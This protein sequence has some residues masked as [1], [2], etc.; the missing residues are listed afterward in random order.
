VHCDLK[1]HNIL[2]DAGGGAKVA[3]FGI[4]HVSGEMLTRSWMTPAGFVAGTLPYMSPEQTDGVRDDPR[5]DVYAVGAVLYRMLTGQTYLDFD[6]RETPL[7]QAVNVQRILDEQPSPPS[8]HTQGI[9]AWLD[10]VV[11]QA[12]AKRPEARYADA[13]TMGAAL[14]QERPAAPPVRSGKMRAPARRWFW[15]VVGA[16]AVLAVVLAIVMAMLLGGGDGRD[17]AVADVTTAPVLP[18]I[19]AFTLTPMPT[20][21]DTHRPGDILERMASPT[22]LTSA[23]ADTSQFGDILERV[24]TPTPLAPTATDRPVPTAT[25]VPPE[26][27]ATLAPTPTPELAQTRNKDGMTM[28]YVP[29][30]EFTMGSSNADIGALLAECSDCTRDSF[31]DEQ[32]QHTVYLDA[33]WI[34]RTEVTNAQFRKCVEAGTCQA[35]T[36]CASG[37]PTYNDPGMGAHPVVCVGWHQANAYC[38]W[39][40]VRLPTEAEWEKAARGTDRRIYAWGN[41]FDGSKANF[42]DLNCE[43][44]Y[45]DGEANDGYGR[46]ALV[47]SYPVGASAYGALDL[48]G[49]VWEWVADWYDADYY[50]DSPASNPRGPS[51]G[52]LRGLRGGSWGNVWSSMRVPN[53]YFTNSANTSYF[54]GFR[55]AA[56]SPGG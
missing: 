2:F 10:A 15:P 13:E 28:V 26:P 24:P 52:D 37:E 27:T 47:G 20:A 44:E 53:R 35:P 25:L 17:T 45:K 42:C 34:D 32:P 55:C 43:F 3:D 33:F 54:V 14:R 16:A 36:T 4:A 5:V 51:S 56:D 19:P 21:T 6:P 7:S 38:V 50:A 39:A 49:N 9:P 46:T 12:L 40:G 18:T 31:K 22:P 30:G 48:T 8:A 29:A 1:P 41:T 23:T 11:L